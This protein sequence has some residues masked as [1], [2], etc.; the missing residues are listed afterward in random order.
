ME[1]ATSASAGEGD[2]CCTGVVAEHHSHPIEQVHDHGSCNANAHDDPDRITAIGGC[3]GE[4][5]NQSVTSCCAGDGKGKQCASE[6]SVHGRKDKHAGDGCTTACCDSTTSAVP[7]EMAAQTDG[8]NC[9]NEDKPECCDGQLH[10]VGC[11][12]AE[13]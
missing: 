10:K 11:C 8:D 2:T 1:H 12:M 13:D 6:S 4:P 5:S 3:C 7:V 9:C